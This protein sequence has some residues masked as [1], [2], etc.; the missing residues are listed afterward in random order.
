VAR[1]TYESLGVRA[2]FFFDPIFD[3]EP[4]TGDLYPYCTSDQLRFFRA[5]STSPRDVLPRESPS[6]RFPGDDEPIELADV[7]LLALTEAMRDV[8]L[9]VGVTSIGSDPEWLD[10]GE[11]RRFENYWTSFAF[12]EL[13]EA[14]KVR[15]EVLERLLPKLAIA[16]R[17]SLGERHL[18]VRG[19]LRTYKIHLGSGNIQM[20]PNDQYLCIVSARDRQADKVWLPFDD[21]AVMS[22]VLSKAF[23]LAND[24]AITDETIIDQIR[25]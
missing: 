9:F 16:D 20:E 1:R 24:T 14:G 21:D 10:R 15:H 4:E 12:G 8:D 13:T 11:G 5:G 22:I 18:M 19:D 17:C 7:P 25:R 3:M 2:E 6:G 23:M